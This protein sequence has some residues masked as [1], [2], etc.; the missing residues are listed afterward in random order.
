MFLQAILSVAR[1]RGELDRAALAMHSTML[2]HGFAS[3]SAPAS[4]GPVMSGGDGGVISLQVLPPDWNATPDCYT[5]HY[6]HPLRESAESFTLKALSIGG[7]L[8]V[9]AASSVQGA[10]LLTVSLAVEEAAGDADVAARMKEWQE[11][12]AASVVLKLLGRQNSTA[13]FA[14]GLG[15]VEQGTK[16]PAPSAEDPR[17]ADRRMDEERRR[18]DEERRRAGDLDPRPGMIDPFTPSLPWHGD[19]PPTNPFPH[20]TPVGGLLGPRHPAWGQFIP[21]RGGGSGSIMPR[22]DPVGPGGGDPDPDHLRVPGMT[23]GNFPAFQGG[24]SG[25]GGRMDPDGMFIL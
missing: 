20:W 9:H 24:A 18:L 11:K 7:S 6:V 21:G 13:R 16:R 2:E 23:P 22:F 19:G 14:K 15:Q 17:A 12:M 10:E 5:F 3:V 25:R 1:V 4:S 8:V